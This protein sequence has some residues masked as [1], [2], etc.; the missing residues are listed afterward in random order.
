MI[1]IKQT[2]RQKRRTTTA[3]SGRSL[4][5]QVLTIAG[6]HCE[7]DV[8][9]WDV[10]CAPLNPGDILAVQTTGAY[11]YV[12]ASNYNRFLKPAVVL[13]NDGNAD[14]IV[15]RETLDDLLRHEVIPARLKAAAAV[16]V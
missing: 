12:M 16:R 3:H 5:D 13:V 11:N 1:L 9:I 10:K 2:V 4:H 15:E 14:L 6:K 7:T 8:L